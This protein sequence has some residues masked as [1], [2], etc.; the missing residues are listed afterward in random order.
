MKL[1]YSTIPCLLNRAGLRCVAF[2]FLTIFASHI[3]QARASEGDAPSDAALQAAPGF[4][5]P[6]IA[7]G[8]TSANENRALARAIEAYRAPQATQDPTVLES[9]LQ[10]YPKSAWRVALLTNLGLTY[11]EEGYFSKAINAWER[12]WR[13]GKNI[14]KR[15][16][17][18]LVDRAV[19]ELLRMHA[20]LG[21]AAQLEALFADIGDRSLSG[22][23]TETFTG[24]SEGLWMMQ[25]DPGVAYLCGPMALKNLL[26]ALG[27][28]PSETQFLDDYRSGPKGVT[29]AEVAKLADQAHL[30]HQIIFRI[31]GDPVPVPSIIH[32]KVS[33][34]AAVVAQ[35]EGRFHIQDP[36]FGTDLWVTKEALDSEA[37]G[38]FLVPDTSNA[39]W[40][41]VNTKEAD[42]IRGMGFTGSSEPATTSCE[43]TAGSS[44][45]GSPGDCHGMCGYNMTEMVVSLNL[46]DT[47]VGYAPPKGPPV[48]VTLAYNQ[49]EANQPATFNYFNVSP[50]WTIN[51]LSF[52]KDNPS[53]AGVSVFR[54]VAG[55][56]SVNYSG[57]V[58]STG[59][60]KRETRDASLLVRVSANP[61]VYERRLADGG[62]EIYSK[63]KPENTNLRRVFLT[64]KIDP[65]GNAVTLNYDDQWRLTSIT[66]ATGRITR[67][68]YALTTNPLLITR[69]TDPFGRSALIG[70]DAGGHLSQITDVVGL[71]SQ[72]T[73]DAAFLVNSM[74][75]PYGTTRFS[76]GQASSRRWLNVTDPLGLTER[77]EFRH[78]VS[79][80]PS[81]DPAATVPQD[82]RLDNRFLQY[83]NTFYW[84]K[85]VYPSIA[86]PDPI[87]ADYKKARITHWHHLTIGT[88]S[89]Q[90]TAH[91]IES[92]KGPLENRIWFTYPGQ[93]TNLSPG[94]IA[95]YYSGTLDKPTG[96]G[97]VLDDGA[98]QRAARIQ[99]ART[100]HRHRRPGRP[101]NPIYLRRQSNRSS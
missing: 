15:D 52:I 78:Q 61:I 99:F 82:M 47:P 18:A 4:E 36:T 37:S 28:S 75:T 81:S 57:Y 65:Y 89:T 3:V 72:F 50:K 39:D 79:G 6:L 2:I 21:H 86:K 46:R 13:E 1:V 30:S 56:G 80:I 33:H 94:G 5:E 55:G 84:D 22:P 26:L 17:K 10:A 7:T 60:F 85:H 58:A 91:S 16:A 64:Q 96:I 88:S 66:D 97:R 34:F 11:Y 77:V 12:A 41:T 73:Y 23:A 90:V 44:G 35:A 20:R 69:I 48:Y 14:T 87:A 24:A 25:N 27:T 59:A 98:T 31:V 92:I 49:R 54:Y 53:N 32:W 93:P 62:V 101:R 40:R 67:F 100:C 9:Y 63:P 38:Y 70:Y 71:T 76:Y 51:W 95:T 83:R 45:C 68:D 19:G 74:I 29:L 8:P 42:R 43:G